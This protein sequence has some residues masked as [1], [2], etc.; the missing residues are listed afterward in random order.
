MVA[1]FYDGINSVLTLPL[2]LPQLHGPHSGAN[3]AQQCLSLLFWYGIGPKIGYWVLDNAFNNDRAVDILVKKLLEHPEYAASRLYSDTYRLR[4]IVHV[5]N[6][7]AH[8]FLKGLIFANDAEERSVLDW[9]KKGP[10]GKL[11]RMV[12]HIR[13]TPPEIPRNPGPRLCW[14]RHG[15]NNGCFG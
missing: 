6:L 5:V 14:S 12:H 3:I 15:H 1:R 7:V 10:I 8:A 13:I 11:H 4:C 2:G 9:R